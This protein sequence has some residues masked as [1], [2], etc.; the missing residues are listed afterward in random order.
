MSILLIKSNTNAAEVY[1]T[2]A[3]QQINNGQFNTN[4]HNI[5]AQVNEKTTTVCKDNA[6]TNQQQLV[7]SKTNQIFLLLK[8]TN[9]KDEGLAS[10]HTK[11]N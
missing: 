6:N 7:Y 10:E 4:K 11:D 8:A 2:Q 5:L 1:Q 9:K 3:R